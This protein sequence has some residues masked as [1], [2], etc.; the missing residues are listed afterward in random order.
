MSRRPGIGMLAFEALLDALNSSAGA[1]YI[2]RN[3][4]VPV[5]FMVGK[6]L[7]PLGRT[8]R[9]HLRL[10]LLGESTQPKRAK[11]INEQRFWSEHLPFVPSDAS[12]LLRRMAASVFAQEAAQAHQHHV[13]Q[14]S[15]GAVNLAAKQAIKSSMRKL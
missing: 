7:M 5:A 3:G 11:E 6:S 12:P 2:A 13:E 4:D 1:L 10:A 14:L 9:G 8:I 15:Q